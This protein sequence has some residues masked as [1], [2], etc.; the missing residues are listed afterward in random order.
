M[1]YFYKSRGFRARFFI[2][3][4]FHLFVYEIPR[5]HI[6]CRLSFLWSFKPI[7]L[8]ASKLTVEHYVQKIFLS[9]QEISPISNPP[10]PRH[11]NIP[12]AHFS[13]LPLKDSD[14][15]IL[16]PTIMLQTIWVYTPTTYNYFHSFDH[17]CCRTMSNNIKTSL[18]SPSVQI[19][20]HYFSFTNLRHCIK[21]IAKCNVSPIK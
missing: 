2:L 13:S 6:A 15:Y 10:C 9:V 21:A 19:L 3:G 16:S 5:W 20:W 8:N 11:L 4:I 7:L 18:L 12:S 17:Q 14:L 1:P